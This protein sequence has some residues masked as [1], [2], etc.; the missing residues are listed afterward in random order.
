MG[1]QAA[2]GTELRAHVNLTDTCMDDET[3]GAI[4]RGLREI[5]V[6]C[7]A[8]LLR[9]CRLSGTG[10]QDLSEVIASQHESI[11]ELDLRGNSCSGS[12]GVEALC[13]LLTHA[14]P[15]ENASWPL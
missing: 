15:K 13:K 10:L 5:A 11:T 4:V 14:A 6:Q 8:L 9:G 2:K 3:V 1:S 7:K 12:D